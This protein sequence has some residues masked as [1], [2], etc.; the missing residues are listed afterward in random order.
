MVDFEHDKAEPVFP[1]WIRTAVPLNSHE[2]LLL[3][4]QDNMRPLLSRDGP[5]VPHSYFGSGGSKAG[6]R[7]SVDFVNGG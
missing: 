7:A 4:Q 5:V 2:L 3:S 6:G 1:M